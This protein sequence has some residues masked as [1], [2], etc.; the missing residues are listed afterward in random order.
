MPMKYEEH[1]TL[2][3]EEGSQ[4][5]RTGSRLLQSFQQRVCYGSP[6]HLFLLGLGLLMLII[7]CVFGCQITQLQRDLLTLRTTS[8]NFS[9]STAAEIQ[10]LK[11]QDGKFQGM[12][13]SVQGELEEHKQQ[14]QAGRGLKDKVLSL[15]SNLEK[16][17]QELRAGHANIFLA[18]QQ[19]AA[20]L[21]SLTCHMSALKGNA[22]QSTCC[23]MNWAEYRGSCYWFSVTGKT[24]PQAQQYCQMEN[25]HLVVVN[26]QEEQNFIQ[27]RIGAINTWMGLTDEHGPWKWE[28]GT[29]YETGFK[30]WRP[31]QPDNWYGHGLGGGEDCAHFTENGA[32]ND[33]V[34]LRPYRWVCETRLTEA[35]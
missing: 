25:A 15:E 4:K 1:Q 20:E 9:S 18:V 26:S 30:N 31:E 16:E 11:S 32:W 19:H 21:R 27:Y 22:S 35:S 33:D 34:C 2:E 3:S 10:A 28:D 17:K 5:F 7:I 29:D 13:T 23:P 6:L 8:L 24:W 12:M 14:L